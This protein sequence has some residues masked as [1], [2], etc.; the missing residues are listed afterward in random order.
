MKEAITNFN[1]AM[2]DLEE[3][4]KRVFIQSVNIRDISPI[5]L[6]LMQS[7]LK[8]ADASVRVINAEAKKLDSIEDKLDKLLSKTEKESQA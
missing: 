2:C 6:K 1:E 7:C 3:V 8:A 4:A 5:E